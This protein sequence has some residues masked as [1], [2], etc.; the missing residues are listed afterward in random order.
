MPIHLMG[1]P[2]AGHR[3]LPATRAGLTAVAVTA[4]LAAGCSGGSGTQASG[5]ASDTA[6]AVTTPSTPPATTSPALAT[7]SA[8]VAAAPTTPAAPTGAPTP[9]PSGS[10]AGSAPC[11]TAHLRTTVGGVAG[12]G[13]AGSTYTAV[14]FVNTGSAS[15]TLNGYPG[16]S[17]VAGAAGSQVGN[18]A[19][20][21]GTASRLA[22]APGA[23]AHATLRIVDYGVYDANLCRPAAVRGFRIYPPGQTA[24]SFVA[25]PG[26]TCAGR[27]V[28]LL[29]VGPVQPGAPG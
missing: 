27:G 14:N 3:P 2:P 18:P 26:R 1:R 22:L 13:T 6:S 10:A 12:G 5:R 11:L 19:R 4:I 23:A 24:S 25:S 15:C 20:R 8:P 29:T 9:S 21:M 7:P 16:V 28:I 17:Y